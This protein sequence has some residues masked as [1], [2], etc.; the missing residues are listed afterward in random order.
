MNVA[1]CGTDGAMIVCWAWSGYR[2]HAPSPRPHLS[3]LLAENRYV[4]RRNAGAEMPG[5]ASSDLCSLDNSCSHAVG[6]SN[7]PSCASTRSIFTNQQRQQVKARQ[8]AEWRHGIMSEPHRGQRGSGI[9]VTRTKQELGV[10]Q[11][12]A[13]YSYPPH[14]VHQFT[15]FLGRPAVTTIF[16]TAAFLTA[17]R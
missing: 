1:T 14:S 15:F 11:R 3:R 6:E 2:Q 5:E 16:L 17:R 9:F 4:I 12:L 8:V 10:N 13:V 7:P